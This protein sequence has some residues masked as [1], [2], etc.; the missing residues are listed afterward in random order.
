[1]SGPL[2]TLDLALVFV[3]AVAMLNRL[4]RVKNQSTALL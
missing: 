2:P 3:L 1:M 4:N